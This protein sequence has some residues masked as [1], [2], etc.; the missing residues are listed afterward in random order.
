MKTGDLKSSEI[1]FRHGHRARL[2]QKFLDGTITDD[3]TL[4]LLLT[5]AIPRCDVKPL[6]RRLIDKFGSTYGVV[7]APIEVLTTIKGIKENTAIFLK[8]VHSSNVISFKN[9]LDSTPVFYDFSKL[10]DYCKLILTGK[11]VEEFHVLYLDS[12]HRLLSDDLHSSGT[13]DWAAVYPREIVKRALELN[14]RSIV[15]VHNHP[16]S[17]T[18]FSHE[19]IVTTQRLKD[20]LAQLGVDLFDHVLVS[21]GVAYSARNLHLFDKKI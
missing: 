17:L 6:M 3:E 21:G 7:T 16:A 20:L 4:E 19:D 13:I 14:A 11:T 1:S 18:S 2:K 9:Y 10:T 5:Y 8:V 12:E 15:M